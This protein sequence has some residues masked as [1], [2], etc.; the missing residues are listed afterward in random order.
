MTGIS[1]WF[2]QDEAMRLLGTEVQCLAEH[3]GSYLVSGNIQAGDS[4]RII[5]AKPDE[6]G[7][8]IA[9]I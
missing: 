9:V 2:T 5:A 3:R 7:W 8:Y 6:Y 4:G 1:D